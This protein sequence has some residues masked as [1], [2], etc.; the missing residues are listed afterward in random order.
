M[1]KIPNYI[2][3]E[4]STTNQEMIIENQLITYNATYWNIISAM[5][6]ATLV[7][8]LLEAIERKKIIKVL[9]NAMQYF[10]PSLELISQILG[11]DF[12]FLQESMEKTK[13]WCRNLSSYYEKI[14]E[15]H[16]AYHSSNPTVC[17]LPS[18]SEQES[19]FVIAQV[20]LSQNAA[21]VRP[22]NRGAGA[23]TA[24]ELI[25]AIHRSVD[26][27]NDRSL[28]ILKKA[29]SILSISSEQ[30]YLQLLSA[31]NW[32]YVFFGTQK[33]IEEMK[34]KLI[35]PA[36][37]VIGYGTGL[38]MTIIWKDA[39]IEK[40]I[41][42][43]AESITVN[44]GNECVSTDIIYIHPSCYQKFMDLFP[45]KALIKTKVREANIHFVERE[46]KKRGLQ[47]ELSF[48]DDLLQPLCI[49]LS[50]YES[51][52]EYP[53]PIVSIRQ[54]EDD[55]EE[56]IEY[57]LKTNSLERN[58]ATAIYT[59]KY[60]DELKKSSKAHI[61]KHNTPTHKVD[62]MLPHQ[63]IYLTRELLDTTFQA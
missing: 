46:L 11:S 50:K 31:K 45:S 29:V 4:P 33:S 12:E 35:L 38:G 55:L 8:P 24:L 23:Y 39:L 6:N 1:K 48:H 30:D 52:I 16:V 26:D 9:E 28:N 36:R 60:F 22:S 32:N 25:N 44:G 19:L 37:K 7:Q 57:D 42:D 51:A 56:L 18:N 58:I 21:I 41:D 10:N 20:L 40:Y 34:K 2:A 13:N 5:K 15:K 61:V 17:I 63:G 54:I 27:F 53:A 14:T 47:I 59:E 3:G 62:L 49:P 43:I